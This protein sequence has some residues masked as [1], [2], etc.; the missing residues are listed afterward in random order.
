MRA[1]NVVF[2]L[3]GCALLS[4]GGSKQAVKEQNFGV[5][6]SFNP[7]KECTT[8]V[9]GRYVRG[10]SCP[11]AELLFISREPSADVQLAGLRSQL[12]VYGHPTEDRSLRING[13]DVPT[14]FYAV[15]PPE[16]PV[17]ASYAFALPGPNGTDS[18]E[19]QCFQRKES[20]QPKRCSVLV[21]SFIS[22]GIQRGEWPS[23]LGRAAQGQAIQ[24]D[25]AS[26]E[27]R[28]P[29]SCDELG[30]FDVD[31]KE[32]HVGAHQLGSEAELATTLA[33]HLAATRDDTIKRERE[34]DCTV[35]GV[36]TTC[37]VREYRLSFGD[38]RFMFS[39]ATLVRDVPLFITCDAPLSKMGL[40]PGPICS[41]FFAFEDGVLTKEEPE[42]EP[43]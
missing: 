5:A 1:I 6:A 24:L 32:G 21:D 2:A 29:T 19:V 12:H 33:G 10:A 23:V 31:C 4:C 7:V 27:V 25:V 36:K 20:I 40:P 38:L 39:A 17:M 8:R 13:R 37:N 16:A 9:Y 41:Q 42:E 30:L 11:N 34:L 35:E 26:R 43:M 14:L 15:G 28:L 22:Q 18:I 3:L